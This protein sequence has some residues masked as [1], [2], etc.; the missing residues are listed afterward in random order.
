MKITLIIICILAI[1][2][3]C[4][5]AGSIATDR[6]K[7]RISSPILNI[8]LWDSVLIIVIAGALLAKIW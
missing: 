5:I 6:I 1:A 7:T 8:I 4:F 3:R 2:W